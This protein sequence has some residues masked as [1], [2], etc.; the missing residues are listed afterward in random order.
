M[1]VSAMFCT[2]MLCAAILCVT[3]FRVRCYEQL[4]PNYGSRPILG[5]KT[6]LFNIMFNGIIEILA[7]NP[8]QGGS[9]PKKFR[10]HCIRAIKLLN[11]TIKH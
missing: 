2:V 6:I 4:P 5:R 7:K 10:N 9:R 8:I 11:Y 1:Y 3:M